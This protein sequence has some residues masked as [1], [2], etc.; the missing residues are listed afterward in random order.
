MVVGCRYHRALAKLCEQTP[1][2]SEHR[3]DALYHWWCAQDHREVLRVATVEGVTSQLLGL[4]P[5]ADII[6][7]LRLAARSAAELQDAVELWRVVLLL[8]ECE[9][10]DRNLEFHESDLNPLLVSLGKVDQAVDRVVSGEHLRIP[11][12][13]EGDAHRAVALELCQ[14]LALAGYHDEATHLFDAAEPLAL[15]R[16]AVLSSH[17][18]TGSNRVLHAWS[19]VAILFRPV[20]IFVAQVRALQWHPDALRDS[21]LPGD[22]ANRYAQNA[23][24]AD[25]EVVLAEQGRWDELDTLL[26]AYDPDCPADRGYRAWGLAHAWDAAHLADAHERA[27]EYRQ[28][29]LTEMPPQQLIAEAEALANILDGTGESRCTCTQPVQEHDGHAER[30][31]LQER[32]R[33]RRRLRVA[34]AVRLCHTVGDTRTALSLIHGIAWDAVI[35]DRPGS[36]VPAES[37]TLWDLCSLRTHLDGTRPAL[38]SVIPDGGQDYEQGRVALGRAFARLACLRGERWRGAQFDPFAFRQDVFAVLHIY[39]QRRSGD[40]HWSWRSDV[41]QRLPSLCD[42]LLREAEQRGEHALAILHS[43]LVSVLASPGKPSCWPD[44]TRRRVLTQWLRVPRYQ[45]WAARELKSLLEQDLPEVAVQE[46]VELSLERSKLYL[47]LDEP[48]LADHWL[49]SSVLLA[50]GVGQE[51]DYQLAAWVRW[52]VMRSTTDPERRVEHLETCARRVVAADRAGDSGHLAARPLLEAAFEWSPARAVDLFQWFWDSDCLDYLGTLDN[53]VSLYA[54]RVTGDRSLPLAPANH[55]FLSLLVPLAR[56]KT[57]MDSLDTILRCAALR[58]EGEL[59]GL[60]RDVWHVAVTEGARWLRADIGQR[61][62]SVLNENHFAPDAVGIHPDDLVEPEPGSV[63]PE[64]PLRLR[65][66]EEMSRDE[67]CQAL[68]DDCRALQALMENEVPT[69][70]EWFERFR[71][72]EVIL[73]A[74]EVLPDSTAIRMYAG[75]L[76]DGWHVPMALVALGRRALEIGDGSLARRL[77]DD[78]LARS[79]PLGWWEHHDGG[80]RRAALELLVKVRPEEY[81]PVAYRQFAE[82]L[83]YVGAKEQA[84]GFAKILPLFDAVH[85]TPALCEVTEAY[86]SRLLAH[87]DVSDEPLPF[88]YRTPEV[89]DEVATALLLVLLHH[90]VHPASVV[91]GRSLRSL[92]ELMLELPGRVA[93]VIRLGLSGSELLQERT[94]MVCDS[95]ARRDPEPLRSLSSALQACQCSSHFTISRMAKRVLRLLGD[96]DKPVS[97]EV[98]LPIPLEWTVVV[99]QEQGLRVDGDVDEGSLPAEELLRLFARAINH[100]AKLADLPAGL[101]AARAAQ[102]MRASGYPHAMEEEERDLRTKLAPFRLPYNRPRAV[103]ARKAM[104]YAVG[105]LFACGRLGASK[106]DDLVAATQACDPVLLPWRAEC[107]RSTCRPCQLRTSDAPFSELDDALVAPSHDADGWVILAERITRWER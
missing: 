85:L 53:W 42:W 89:P 74:A 5:P 46:R 102:L 98:A 19:E 91:V 25:A 14:T 58:G 70:G 9:Q 3:W 18:P 92:A 82:D 1:D 105:E 100:A 20:A 66:G 95:V 48:A 12:H 81:R 87:L 96:A 7:D 67:V 72:D 93:P 60:A 49:Q 34:Y 22:Q 29:L 50:L 76:H 16:T 104:N 11:R 32:L 103:L 80:S 30:G 61:I 68:R 2:G 62:G 78:A 97:A 8:S 13:R 73:R 56:E 39:E 75:A 24:L 65:T 23:L 37:D 86:V 69:K 38:A 71:W 40:T 33:G 57:E 88:L 79:R 26:G 45:Q 27:E 31:W 28:R 101:L 63:I 47:A 4:R 6:A 44:Y 94:L 59:L 90:L 107:R 55:V 17:D 83:A 35:K 99:P 54:S 106:L 51:D 43:E 10:R 84:Q 21:D 36:V 52:A 15:L 41:P 77:G 64:R